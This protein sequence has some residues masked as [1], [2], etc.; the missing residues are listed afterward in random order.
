MLAIKKINDV[1]VKKIALPTT[2]TSKIKGY[3]MIPE[4]YANIFICA[5]K[6]QGKTVLLGNILKQCST[7]DTHVIF[8]VSTI[9]KD[10]TYKEILL[11]LKEK[12]IQF[13]CFNSINDGIQDNLKVI[14]DQIKNTPP[15]PETPDKKEQKEPL[16]M[17][18]DEDENELKIT[19]RKPSKIAPKYIFVFDDMSAEIKNNPNIKELLKQNRHYLSKVIISSQYVNDIAPDSRA[20]I[21]VW[22]LFGGH[23]DEKLKDIWESSDPVVEFDVFKI[24]YNDATSEQYNFLFIDKNTGSYRKNFNQEYVLPK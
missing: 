4:L 11:A 24:L 19:I 16:V 8:F 15:P 21:D 6:K 13:T 22:L 18:F 12:K 7:K 17:R 3:D 2:D 23:T 10:A 14:V 9:M 5:R 20:M 1:K